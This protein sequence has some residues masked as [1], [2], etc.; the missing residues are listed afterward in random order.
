MAAKPPSRSNERKAMAQR[1]L[2]VED[3]ALLALELEQAM[4][5]AG[6]MAVGP[7]LSAAQ[8]I[9]L[10]KN[11]SFDAAV[12]DINLRGETSADVADE[13]RARNIPFI[14]IPGYARPQ[15]PPVFDGV[16]TLTKPVSMTVVIEELRRLVPTPGA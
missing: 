3:N 11:S 13:L 9:E 5:E 15:Q 1:V 10:V 7:A 8:A 2:I 16:P 12:L 4:Q 6:F 14:T